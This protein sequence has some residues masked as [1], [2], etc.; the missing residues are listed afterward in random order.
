MF[1]NPVLTDSLC[2][3]GVYSVQTLNSQLGI[4]AHNCVGCFALI[5]LVGTFAVVLQGCISC[6]P[7]DAFVTHYRSHKLQLV[8]FLFELI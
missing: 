1:F 5:D 7:L 2:H 8:K 3:A 4:T 6:T